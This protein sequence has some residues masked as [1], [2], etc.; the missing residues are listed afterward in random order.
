MRDHTGGRSA[1]LLFAVDCDGPGV[2]ELTGHPLRLPGEVAFSVDGGA[3]VRHR[4][5]GHDT[6]RL[7]FGA[8]QNHRLAIVVADP[9]SPRLLSGEADERILGFRL[10]SVRI[11]DPSA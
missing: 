7:D 9:T 5:N 3:P 1:E 10:V 4:Y 6:V 8:A 2:L 11:A